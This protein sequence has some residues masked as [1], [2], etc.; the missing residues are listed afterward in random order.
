MR[1]RGTV[2]VALVLIFSLVFSTGSVYAKSLSDI[3]K[4]IKSKQQELEEGKNKEKELS[5]EIEDLEKKI[6][7]AENQM[8]VLRDKIE[9]TEDKVVTAEAELKKAE[10][11]VETQNENLNVRLRTMYKNGS[12]GFL[13]VLLG[14]GSISEFISNLDMVKK[15]YSSDKD[16][17][18]DLQDDYDKI[19]KKKQELTS[20]QS[21]LENQKQE[22]MDKQA[23]LTAD[24]NEVTKKKSSVA[25]SNNDLED[26]IHDLNSEAERIA[27]IIK[28]DSSS[29][30]GGGSGGSSYSSG[31]FTY[32]VPGYTRVS[33]DYGWRNCPFHGRELHSGTDF[34]APYGTSVVA[35]AKG[36][37]VFSGYLGSYGNAVIIS[38]GG[39]LY[40]L[41][42]HN[43]SLVVSSGAKVS[44]GQKIARI[45]STGSSTGNHCHFEVRKGGNSRGNVVSPWNY[46]K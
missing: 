44:K 39:G 12:I 24:K 9:N 13:D 1:K 19:E 26:D 46:L 20:L 25:A 42:G 21:Q 27:S 15:I 45:G 23:E 43:S 31:K 8:E 3:K 2:V 18:A 33:S 32:P 7:D 30:S 22:Q 14:S 38:H 36:T 34:P 10:E 40:T 6:G 35:A 11:D 28:N 16:V 29:N 41:Y 4:E 17:L 37:V 5:S